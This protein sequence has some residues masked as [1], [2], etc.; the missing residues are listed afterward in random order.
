[1]KIAQAELQATSHGLLQE[2][3]GEMRIAAGAAGG[4]GAGGGPF[5]DDKLA[6]MG[7]KDLANINRSLQASLHKMT[8]D[9]N[10]K[11][12]LQYVE[13]VLT[14]SSHSVPGY[15]RPQNRPGAKRNIQ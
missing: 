9:Q 6:N 13:G 4:A 12:Y 14:D 15:D 7:R 2:R 1:M 5:V 8:T 11:D 10:D 3:M